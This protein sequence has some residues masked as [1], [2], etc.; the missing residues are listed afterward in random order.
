MSI[1][2]GKMGLDQEQT[3]A[4]E[5]AGI[6]TDEE[7]WRSMA[8]DSAFPEKVF[9]DDPAAAARLFDRLADEARK[10]GEKASASPLRA[11]FPDVFVLVLLM[12]AIYGF[13]RDRTGVNQVVVAATRGIPAFH[14]ISPVDLTVLPKPL[15][16]GAVLRKEE[17]IGRY[18][19]TSLGQG[20]VILRETLSGP[21]LHGELAGRRIL[22]I[23]ALP[24]TPAS[25]LKTPVIISLIASPRR[26]PSAGIVFPD[27]I[28]LAVS[29]QPDGGLAAV[30]AVPADDEALFA[31]LIGDSDFV[32]TTAQ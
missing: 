15:Q 30:I 9:L 3:E 12:L 29:V 27:V 10:T 28:L 25:S 31:P 26:N 14:P 2:I 5:Q 24:S 19:S 11:H 16:A 4:L 20:D 23:K 21:I 17:V 8:G 7:L 13:F 6:T 32:I 1:R 18:S 22:Q